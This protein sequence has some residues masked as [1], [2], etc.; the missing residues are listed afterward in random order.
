M[1][2]N[3]LWKRL[4]FIDECICCGKAVALIQECDFNGRTKVIKR[5]SG[6]SAV[7]LRDKLSFNDRFKSILG[8]LENERLLFNRFG[9][10]F[11]FNG[12][13]IATNERFLQLI[14]SIP[15]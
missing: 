1:P 8:S 7:K 4:Y 10:I 12:R 13:K 6:D 11:N 2:S 9:L 15:A 3:K 5:C 14:S